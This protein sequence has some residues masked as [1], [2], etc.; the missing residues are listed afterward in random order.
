MHAMSQRGT[1]MWRIRGWA[2]LYHPAVFTPRRDAS[3]L[4]IHSKEVQSPRARLHAKDERLPADGSP[5]EVLDG[6]VDTRS[7]QAFLHDFCIVPLSLQASRGYVAGLEPML[8]HLGLDS[9]LSNACRAVSFASPGIKLRRP[10]LTQTAGRLYHKL[11]GSLAKAVVDPVLANTPE[12][13]MMAMLLGLYEVSTTLSRTC[14]SCES[15]ALLTP[16]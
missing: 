2:R 16:C 4:S 1:H 7:I 8:L 9:D 6:E 12:S 5:K 10:V 3:N 15:F 14:E 13:L 11:L